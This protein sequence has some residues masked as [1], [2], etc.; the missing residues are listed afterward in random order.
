MAQYDVHLN[1]GPLRASVPMVVFV[2][3]G[4]FDGYRRRVVVPLVLCSALPAGA[5]VAGT[6]LNPV[7]E[8]LGQSVVLH[9][10]DMVSVAMDQLGAC[11]GSLADQGQA[12]ADALDELLTRSWG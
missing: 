10:L 3:S 4:L 7:F 2:Q 12:V 5:K 11:V 1:P 8:L 6:R 9:P